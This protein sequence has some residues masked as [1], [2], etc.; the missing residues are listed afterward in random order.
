M[1]FHLPAL[2]GQPTTVSN[3]C[4]AYTQKVR[5][6]A[7]MMMERDHEVYLY[8]GNN[9]DA[10]CT[11]YIECYTAEAP[12]PFEDHIWKSQNILVAQEINRRL[13]KEKDEFLCLIAG[14]CQFA[15]AQMVPLLPVE[16]GIGYSA[17]FSPYRVFESYAWMHTVYGAAVHDAS[18]ADGR[19]FDVVIPNYFD[20]EEFPYS[21]EKDDYFL[22]VG[23]LIER[24]GINIASQAA[25]KAGVRLL[26]AGE[27]DFRPNYGEFLGKTE[28]NERGELMSKARALLVPTTYIEPFGGV[29]VEAMLCGTPVI[30][31]DWGAFTETFTHGKQGYRCRT[32]G[33]FIWAI[34]NLNS[35]D[36]PSDIREYAQKNF[37]LE[38]IAPKYEAYFEQ[39]LTLYQEGWNSDWQGLSKTHRYGLQP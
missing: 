4:C 13:S 6:F 32:L 7:K 9:N 24:K 3:S 29:H 36:L 23:R 22:F 25:E 31:T 37:S 17:P 26:I 12:I 2:P 5:K 1:R 8:G 11:E 39:L 14:R 21:R 20:I 30:T 35:L 15:L 18:T 27:G 10:P 34:D 19:F 38:A 16:F 33:E 28:P